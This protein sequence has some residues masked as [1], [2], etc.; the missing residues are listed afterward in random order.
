MITFIIDELIKKKEQEKDNLLLI[1]N[2]VIT[3]LSNKE[4]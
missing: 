1:K 3:Y 2:I 4:V